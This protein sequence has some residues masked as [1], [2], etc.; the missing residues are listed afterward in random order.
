M[1]PKKRIKSVLIEKGKSFLPPPVQ[2]EGS[3]NQSTPIFSLC[4]QKGYCLTDCEKDEK[5]AFAEKLYELSR[6]T[7]NEII[8]SNRHKGGCEKIKRETIN[9]PIPQH[10][11]EDV[12]FF[13]AIRFHG[14]RPMVG[15]RDGV[16]LHILWLDRNF[17]LYKH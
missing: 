5:V 16:I 3:S 4:F 7:W 15:Y 10:I 2:N 17:K 8:N 11:T 12:K 9:S 13:I 14:L 6:K 1:P